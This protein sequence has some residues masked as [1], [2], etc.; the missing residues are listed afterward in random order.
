MTALRI[1]PLFAIGSLRAWRMIE[2]NLLVYKHG[3]LVLLSGFF[4][5]LFYLLSIGFG[6]GRLVGDVAGPGGQ[7]IPYAL[8]V[9]PALLAA[10]SMNGAITESTFNFFFKLNYDKTFASILTTPMSPG[11]ISLGELAWAL[12]R[13]ALYSI[14][15][16]GV[17]VVF[18]LVRSPL[19]L[20]TLPASLLIG[21]AFAAVGMAATSF[22]RTWQ[23][24]DLIQL[25]ILPMFLFSGTFFPIDAVPD[26]VR[27][28]IQ[29]TPLYHGVEMLRTLSVGVVGPDTLVHVAYLTVMG[30][31][32]IAV[33]SRRLDKL[34]L[35]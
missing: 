33:V 6:L 20:L 19:V 30:L 13:G 1:T 14:G 34:L 10:S 31:F 24:F 28:V 12:M 8:F 2:R 15:F 17:M 29:L 23:D 35:K 5:P 27:L 9:A 21:F 32:G 4:E 18:G 7:Q 22:M 16:L 26:G 25:V 11:D 3:W